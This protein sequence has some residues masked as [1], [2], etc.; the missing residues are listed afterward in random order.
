MTYEK[1]QQ[2]ALL[3]KWK[4]VPYFHANII[5]ADLLNLTV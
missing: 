2:L 1:S 3:V 5:G 4:V